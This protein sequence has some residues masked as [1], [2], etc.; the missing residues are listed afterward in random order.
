ML[1]MRVLVVFRFGIVVRDGF[2]VILLVITPRCFSE[3]HWGRG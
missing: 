2:V 1:L 3:V